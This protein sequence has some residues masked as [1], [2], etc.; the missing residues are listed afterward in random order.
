L[1]KN[2]K[3]HF[4][5]VGERA[6]F[7][8]QCLVEEKLDVDTDPRGFYRGTSDDAASISERWYYA[9]VKDACKALGIPRFSP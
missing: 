5:K 7:S 3:P 2:R 4:A 6:W 8:A 1:H 9:A